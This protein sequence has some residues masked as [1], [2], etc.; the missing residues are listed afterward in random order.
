MSPSQYILIGAAFGHFVPKF[1]LY[2]QH[3]YTW[4]LA[5][6]Q[7]ARAVKRCE[8]CQHSRTMLVNCGGTDCPVWIR[9]CVECWALELSIPNATGYTPIWNPNCTDPCT[10]DPSFIMTTY[11]NESHMRADLDW[12]GQKQKGESFEGQEKAP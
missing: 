8:R 6:K 10:I 11:D 9:K 4:W 5:E 12:L 7:Y 2:A 3:R 1:A